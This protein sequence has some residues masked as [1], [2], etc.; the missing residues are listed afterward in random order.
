MSPLKRMSLPRSRRGVVALAA[1]A[2]LGAAGLHLGPSLPTPAHAQRP[3]VSVEPGAGAREVWLGTTIAL[4]FDRAVDTASVE[5]AITVEPAAPGAFVWQKDRVDLRPREPLAPRTAYKVTLGTGARDAQGRPLVTTPF[6]WTFTTGEWSGNVTFGY[7]APVQL[8]APSGEHGI[9]VYPPYPRM[10]LDFAAYAV[11]VPGFAT[12]YAAAVPA[13]GGWGEPKKIDF[14]GLARVAQW[15]AAVDNSE[16]MTG[17]RL[18]KGVPAGLYVVDVRHPR[19]GDAQAL[20]VYTDHTVVAK[21]GRKGLLA[22]TTGLLDARP[23]GGA[24]VSLVDAA[25]Q[26]L[27]QA[28]ADADGIARFADGGDARFAVAR[29]G[30]Q[31]TLVGLDSLWRSGGYYWRWWDGGWWGAEAPDFAGHVHTDRPIYRPGHV[32]HY[33]ATLRRFGDDGLAVIAPSTPVS[34]TV[35]DSKGNVVQRSA[36]AADGFGSVAGDVQL[37]DEVALGD[38]T[39]QAQ[40]EGQ[41]FYGYFKVEDYVKPDFEVK[42]STDRPFYVRDETAQVTVRADYYFGQPAAGADATLRV[43]RGYHYRGSGMQPVATLTGTLGADGAWTAAVALPGNESYTEQVTLEAEVMDATRRPVV[44]STFVPVHPAAFTLALTSDRYGVEAGQPAVYTVQTMAHDGTPAAGRK[45]GVEVRQWHRDGY[46]TIRT[47]SATT[48]ADGTAQVSFTDLKEGWFSVVAQAVD[49]A[50]RRIE[51]TSYAWV[52]SVAYPWYWWGGLELKTDKPSYAPGETLRLLVKSPVTTTALVTIERDEVHDE[53]IVPVKGGTTVELPIKPEY[54]PNVWV[55]VQLWQPSDNPWAGHEGQ[56]LTATELVSVP[57][58][59]RRLTVEV[60]PGA[61]TAAPGANAAFTIRVRD[62]AGRPVDAQVSLALV[63]KAVLALTADRSGDIFDAFWGQWQNAVQ[64]Y[65]SMQVG[66]TY[67]GREDAGA[68]PPTAQ[69]GPGRGDDPNK[70]ADEAVPPAPRREFKDTAY[71]N[72]ALVT[73]PDG[74]VD[75]TVALPDN[76]TTWRAIARAITRSSEAGQGAGELVVTQ[77][78]IAEPALPRFAVQGDHFLLDVLGRNYAGGTLSGECVLETPGLVQLDPGTRSLELPFNTTK[79]ARW[80]VVASQV[81]VQPILSRLTTAGGQD[82]I[83]LP[84]EVQPFTVPERFVRSG[85]TAATVEERID[86]PFNAV[87]DAST[88]EIRVTPGMAVGVLD[89]V[90]ELIGYPYGCVEQTMSRVLPNAVVGRLVKATGL[91]VPEV[92]AKLP[93]YVDLGLQKLYG[94]QN[95]DG[96]WGWWHGDGNVYTTAYVLHGLAL[97]RDAGFDV[98]KAVLDR[99]FMWLAQAATQ[100]KDP[101]MQ[102]YAVYVAAAAGYGDAEAA[103]R[104]YSQRADLDA[105]GLG[106]A[107]LALHLTGQA[108]LAGRAL[109]ALAAR[110]KTGPATAW[111][112][113][114]TPTEWKWDDYHWRS[115][116]STEKNTGMAL[117]ALATLRPTDTLAPKAARWLMEHRWGRAWPTTQATAF[118]ILGLTDFIVASGELESDYDWTVALDGVT[119]ASGTVDRSNVL[120]PI[121]PVVLTGPSLAPGAHALSFTKQGQGT[122]Y[123]T[124][125]G[126]MAAYYPAFEPTQAEGLGID[127]TRAYTPIAGRSDAEGWHVGDVVNVR[128]TVEVADTLQYVLIEDK[129][130]AGLEGLNESLD[131]ETSR[132]PGG[133]PQPGRPGGMPIWRWWGYERKEV[134]ADKVTFFASYLPAGTHVFEYAARAVTPGTFAARPAEAY[135]MYRPDVWGRSASDQV[136][137]DAG[138]V[139][140]RPALAGDFDRD[141][142]LTGFDASLVAADWAAGTGRDLT[143]NGRVSVAD[144]ATAAGRAGRVCGDAVPPLPGAAGDLALTLRAPATVRQGDAFDLEVVVAG[145]GEI[146][147]YELTLRLPAGAFEVLGA[148]NGDRVPGAV[149]LAPRVDATAGTVRFGGWAAQG[150]DGGGPTVL[151]RLRLRPLRAGAARVDVADSEV[152]TASGGAFRVTATGAVIGPEP[153]EPVARLFLPS[154]WQSVA[155]R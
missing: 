33:K 11:D 17:V 117:V 149:V 98:D 35:R 26:P 39:V 129:L 37:G 20:V 97:T 70:R 123:Y 107:A 48:G 3:V 150:A 146:G 151:A 7:G 153:W 58:D 137:I 102:A 134:R 43:Y 96:S 115:M 64:T 126:Q 21:Q 44:G 87:P 131:T 143:G 61:P 28:A 13:D 127:I 148:T 110:A 83:E 93:A 92:T 125:L 73:G 72:A 88:L 121:A 9:G 147:A 138:R 38:W 52:Y 25:G 2:A 152:V 145:A 65:D 86:V 15:S 12:R 122:L 6:A 31:T 114:E 130:P 68:G 132:V 118:A 53:L 103:R 23:A 112:P 101:R 67:R 144:I 79:V 140:A 109:D 41:T 47:A 49:D 40:V 4:S 8:L 5:A 29:V 34:V 141:C 124:V 36:P 91:D 55:K 111:W 76:L 10:T 128:L 136:A 120:R 14:G 106:A 30:D 42:L 77:P 100:E 139:R 142:R 90:E 108:E 54:A 57:A 22:W 27:A 81:G 105:F 95:T 99:G 45:V 63:D 84:F 82:G 19:G 135:P 18:P 69:P 59:D 56:L 16:T 60:V 1:A 32:V 113:I 74:D 50:G 154:A 85:A 116:A 119:V 46:A 62:A 94:F 133:D 66:Q 71:W 24:A 80:S 89:G 78:I 104:L 51:T 155:P 75:V